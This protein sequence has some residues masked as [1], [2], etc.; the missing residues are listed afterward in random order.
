MSNDGR[1]ASLGHVLLAKLSI[2][3]VAVP[4]YSTSMVSWH[5]LSILFPIGLGFVEIDDW[6]LIQQCYTLN[7]YVVIKNGSV[8]L[9]MAQI[10][11]IFKI[12]NILSMDSGK[13]QSR[14][15]RNGGC[16]KKSSRQS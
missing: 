5:S 6:L 12:V 14:N 16:L 13:A 7:M 1:A 2:V 8:D 11:L 10:V 9:Q 15:L 3:S 4:R